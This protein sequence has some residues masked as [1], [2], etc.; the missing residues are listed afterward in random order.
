MVIEAV[1]GRDYRE[2]IRDKVLAPLGLAGD[3]FVGV[4]AE[5]Q[6]RCADTYA[7]EP[8][9]NSPEFKAAGMPSGGGY[10][11]ARG[12]AAVYHKLLRQGRLG[13]V[14]VLAP[15]LLAYVTENP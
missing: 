4:P 5:E 8:R 9:D 1:S 13:G 6:G 12:M 11:A 2:V 7:A 14:R 3:I 10:A 15:R